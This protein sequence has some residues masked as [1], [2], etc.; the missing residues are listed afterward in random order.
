MI[1]VAAGNVG[2]VAVLVDIVF[3]NLG[4]SGI[5]QTVVIGS[6]R[7]TSTSNAALTIR[8]D[9]VGACEVASDE[10]ARCVWIRAEC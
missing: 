7:R 9:V 2:A 4:R 10:A 6:I 3:A 8:R 1:A 5:D